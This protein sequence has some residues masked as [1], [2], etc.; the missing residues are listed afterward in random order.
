MSSYIL[1]AVDLMPRAFWL[2]LILYSVVTGAF[3][4]LENKSP[5]KTIA[6]LLAFWALPII[7]VVIYILFGREYRFFS[8]ER[9]LVQQELGNH[10]TSNP[11]LY[12][13]LNRQAEEI[14]K[15]MDAHPLVYDRVLELMRRN[16]NAPLY[17]HNTVEIL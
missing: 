14:Q 8:R 4:I 3:I 9:K 6:W 16:L 1:Q 12:K 5:E 11:E 2:M 15:L 7:G 17:P 13:F 10:L